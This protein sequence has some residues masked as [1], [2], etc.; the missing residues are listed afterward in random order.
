MSAPI[1]HI[2]FHYTP[3]WFA[4]G[5]YVYIIT[6]WHEGDYRYYIGQTGDRNHLSARSPFY[7]LW[8]HFNPYKSADGQLFQ[9]LKEILRVDTRKISNR[10]KVESS[11]ASG[12]ISIKADYFKIFDLP[13]Q[14]TRAE[15][16]Q[17]RK[18]VEDVESLII[19]AIP[20]DALIN[21]NPKD[22]VVVDNAEALAT[23]KSILDQLNL[24]INGLST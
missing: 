6:V 3:E 8:G 12:I 1:Q 22:S 21:K 16:T 4:S 2:N 23:A 5:Y 24:Y 7:R 15:H 17:M 9:S 18:H 19:Q 10:V 20:K 11:I 13:E 14:L